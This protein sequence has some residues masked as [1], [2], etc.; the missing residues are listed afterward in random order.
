MKTHSDTT[1]ITFILPANIFSHRIHL[2]A[3][4]LHQ[5]QFRNESKVDWMRSFAIHH[6]QNTNYNTQSHQKNTETTT[7]KQHINV[8][9]KKHHKIFFRDNLHK[10]PKCSSTNIVGNPSRVLPARDYHWMFTSPH[11]YAI[12][13]SSTHPEGTPPTHFTKRPD[14][15]QITT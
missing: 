7:K 3:S 10:M 12:R 4:V 13:Q 15:Q 1:C 6:K 9:R 5:V 2:Q 11:W 14:F 8:N